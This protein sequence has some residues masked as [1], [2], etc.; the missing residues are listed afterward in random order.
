MNQVRIQGF[1]RELLRL[2]AAS[3]YHLSVI[4]SDWFFLWDNTTTWP[5]FSPKIFAGL[6]FSSPCRRSLR[7]RADDA[8]FK[9][10]RSSRSEIYGGANFDRANSDP[11]ALPRNPTKPLSH[12]L[13][14][15]DRALLFL[16]GWSVYSHEG[17]V[18]RNIARATVAARKAER[19]RHAYYVRWKQMRSYRCTSKSDSH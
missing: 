11:V 3:Y 1:E 16:R 9:N 18:W 6:P 2:L 14:T 8:R 12:P 10:S 5:P 19:R 7:H 15:C 13:F 4:N 17:V